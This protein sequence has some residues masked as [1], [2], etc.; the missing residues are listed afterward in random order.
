VFY[1]M[2]RLRG[3]LHLGLEVDDQEDV[4]PGTRLGQE[5]DGQQR[6]CRD[7]RDDD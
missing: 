2:A 5:Q 1:I 4:A 7:V 3:G 6:A